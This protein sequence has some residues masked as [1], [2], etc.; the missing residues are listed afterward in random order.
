MTAVKFPDISWFSIEVVTM[1]TAISSGD[2]DDDDDND[3]DDG[4][5]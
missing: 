3:D 1:N 4:T 5:V 2:D